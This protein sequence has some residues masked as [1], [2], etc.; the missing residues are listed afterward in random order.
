MN[1]I[2]PIPEKGAVKKETASNRAVAPLT[3]ELPPHCRQDVKT[4]R[5]FVHSVLSEGTP[6]EAVSPAEFREVLLTGATGF[7]GR[8]VLRDLLCRNADLVVHCLV[9]AD[10]SR[11]GLQRLR[12]ALEEA[13]IRDDGF[14]PRIRIVVGD[15]TVVR[16]GLNDAQF[17]S[18]CRKIDAVFHLAADLS[19]VSPYRS[20]RKPN[21][22]STR[23]VIE[24]CLH[25]RYKHLFYASTLAVFPEFFCGGSMESGDSH[26][27]IEDQMQPDLAV[28]KRMIPVGWLGYPWSKLVSEQA[29]LHAHAAGLPL[30]IFRF[31]RT[32]SAASTGY[33]NA[34]DIGMR[35]MAGIIDVRMMPRGFTIHWRDDPV[36]VLSRIC[37]AISMNP[38]R[39]YTIY[40]CCES[41]PDDH[42]IELPDFGLHF[43][44]VPYP[45]FKRACLARGEGSPLHGFWVLLDHFAPYWFDDQ[46]EVRPVSIAD[47][48]IREDCPEPIRWP[49]IFTRFRRSHDWV[50]SHR[51]E[52]PYIVPQSRLEF[53]ALITRAK[54][55]AND[56]GVSFELTYPQWMQR[57]LRELVQALE[58]PD[59]R[60]LDDK[61]S[62]VVFDLSR[63]LRRIAALAGERRRHP[64][65][66]RE[67]IR[68][69]VFIVGINRTGTTFLH[70][71]MDRDSRFW[72]LRIYELAEPVLKT[73]QYASVAGTP[74]DPRRKYIDEVIDTLGSR[75]TLSGIHHIDMDEP[76]EDFPLLSLAFA[77]RIMTLRYHV[78]GYLRWLDET[79]SRNAYAY[80]RRIMQHYTW[81]RRQ[82]WP[83]Q[84]GQWLFKMPGHLMELEA[85]LEVYPDALFIQTHRDPRQFMGS[86]NNLV[87]RVRA[88]SCGP[89]PRHE[90]G[91]EQLD[92][93]SGMLNKA[94][95]FRETHP[96]L[97]NRWA[98]VRYSDLVRNPLAT[99]RRIYDRFGWTLGQE[100]LDV[101]ENWLAKQAEKRGQETRHQYD[102]QDYGLEPDA[103]DD[104]FAP[105]HDFITAHGIGESDL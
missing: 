103:V 34:D 61:L 46:K 78:P 5:R 4:L 39:L 51:R 88:Q 74:D 86:W 10:D 89:R 40:H 52:W 47:R 53:D 22:S 1:E 75:E 32:M 96:E 49:G 20:I 93:M 98:D 80:H 81:Q 60:L 82:R 50:Q 69:P 37:T 19:L 11:H 97:E 90:F 95:R 35:V 42:D 54:Y 76:E 3:G 68:R 43:P 83:G 62:E 13:G 36:D 12:R 26:N 85:L 44:E 100:E 27:R 38:E 63:T 64:E 70:R 24:L 77:T 16:F 29:L 15:V 2:Q 99:V 67:V 8:H 84:P 14:A 55:F 91:A 92:F 59:A 7:I 25:T 57:G 71:L 28:M 31:P 33:T 65:I 21:V 87:G 56:A 66:E 72:S 79:G 94:A 73:E 45:V 30:A 17:E 102:L 101:M 41:Q 48:A 105:Y 6:A 18:L 23:N 104:A 9:R 58:A